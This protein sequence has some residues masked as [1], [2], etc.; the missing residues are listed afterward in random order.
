MIKSFFCKIAL[1]AAL[2]MLSA[3]IGDGVLLIK[4]SIFDENN[5]PVNNCEL[6][7]FTASED[8][9]LRFIKVDNDFDVGFTTAP[10]AH[11]YYFMIDCGSR[12]HQFKTPIY[13]IDGSSYAQRPLDLGRI[14]MKLKSAQ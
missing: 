11:E 9:K 3:C 4:G 6:Q 8:R 7:I 5:R 13:K 1:T 12:Y 14:H 10:R 2:F